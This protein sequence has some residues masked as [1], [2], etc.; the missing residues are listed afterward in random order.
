MMPATEPPTEAQILDREHLRLLAIGYYIS[1]AATALFVSIFLIHFAFVSAFAIM[2]DSFWKTTNTT[3]R[4]S[5]V[6]TNLP[7]AHIGET[8]P[9][10]IL[11]V[12]AAVIG[13]II[14]CG[15][16]LGGLTIYA[17]KS[18]KQRKRRNFVL[19]MAAIKCLFIPYG[20]ALGIATFFVLARPAVKSQFT[21]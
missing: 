15:W 12:F 18:I 13:F 3:V 16:T 14:I 1:G 19:V 17:G 8:P 20:T 10:A 9:R 7:P 4:A 2:P 11:G 5:V 21:T 6:S